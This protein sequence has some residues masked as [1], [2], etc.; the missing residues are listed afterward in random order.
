M[1]AVTIVFYALLALATTV[2][3]GLS[4][5]QTRHV[6]AHRDAV[7]ADFAAV[8]SLD[9]HQHAADYS[10]AKSRLERVELL[11]SLAVTLAWTLGGGITALQGWAQMVAGQ[12]G[13]VAA[14]T[15]LILAFL[16]SSSL[17]GIPLAVYRT[18]V[19]E[20]R[21]GFN[22]TTPRIFLTDLLTSTALTLLIGGPLIALFLW[23][24]SLT[25]SSWWMW[26]WALL[27]LF[28]LVAIWVMPTFIAPLFNRFTP[29]TDQVLHERVEGLL[30]RTG[31]R[32]AGLFV[33]DASRR[34]GHGNAYFTGLGNAK[35]IVLF[36]TLL[37]QLTHEQVEAVLAHEIGHDK[38]QHIRK[39]IGFF[40]ALSFVAFA[41]L[42]WLFG[43]PM[44]WAAL[45]VHN[46]S[47]GALLL[48]T[49][50]ALPACTFFID[51]LLAWRSRVHE[52]EAD[53]YARTHTSADAMVGALVSLYRDNAGTLT[54][55][56]LYAAW[57]YSHPPA[58][59][60]VAHIR[61][62]AS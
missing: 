28:Q 43:Q 32:A 50:V 20:V 44:V 10:N 11:L 47:M 53:A 24:L 27:N 46:P 22:K 51:P 39:M 13:M 52:F 31:Y 30:T 35:R 37:Q 56:P 33:M 40:A 23:V 1:T 54:P 45:G 49:I 3:I 14:D 55:D 5:R 9:T 62:R 12:W 25:G 48:A 8:I 41:L 18:F 34:S 2:L 59:E 7:P 60:R 57:H 26:G 61:Q 29:L 42:G 4:L 16:L 19:T 21:Y 38:K 58:S 36:D 6:R 17:I 15:V